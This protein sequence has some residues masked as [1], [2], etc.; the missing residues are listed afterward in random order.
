MYT[1]TEIS[2]IVRVSR[3]IILRNIKNG[4]LKAYKRKYMWII[5]DEEAERFI[6]EFVPRFKGHQ[7]VGSFGKWLLIKLESNKLTTLSIAK[8][9]RLTRSCVNQ[10]INGYETCKPTYQTVIA[11]CHFLGG[12]P[13]EI[14]RLVEE[15]WG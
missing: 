10:H 1:V 6:G 15:D 4:K 7:Y 8:K 12:D 14:W 11:Y 9:M 2:E 5:K 3:Q 13:E